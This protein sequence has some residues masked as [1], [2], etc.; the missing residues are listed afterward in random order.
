MFRKHGHDLIFMI[1]DVILIEK[2]CFLQSLILE[3]EC[4]KLYLYQNTFRN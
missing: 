2:L 1:F 3:I 4:L